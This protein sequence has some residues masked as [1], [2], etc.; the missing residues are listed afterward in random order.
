MCVRNKPPGEGG[1]FLCLFSSTPVHVIL[2]E[3]IYLYIFPLFWKDLNL[4]K[5]RKTKLT[6]RR[7]CKN[8][9]DLEQVY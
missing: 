8:G 4:M 7:K 1:A 9:W 5:P 6:K 3:S 2:E